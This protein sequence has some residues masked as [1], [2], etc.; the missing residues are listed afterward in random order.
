MRRCDRVGIKKYGR[1]HFLLV[2]S[3]VT[4]AVEKRKAV[5]RG[6]GGIAVQRI[7]CGISCT[8]G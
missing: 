3:N 7:Y 5:I 2:A 4:V 6:F 1:K 8:F